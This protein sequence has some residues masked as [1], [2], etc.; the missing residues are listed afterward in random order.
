MLFT[1]KDY[2][3]ETRVEMRGGKGNVEYDELIP[4][5]IPKNGRVFAK[6]TLAPGCSI[7]KHVHEGETEIYTF[8]EGTGIAMDDDAPV[9]VQPGYVMVTPSGHAHAVENDG[10]ADLVFYACIILGE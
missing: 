2:R 9:K 5:A 4:G 7:G 3:H 6:L 1:P 10:D 8:V